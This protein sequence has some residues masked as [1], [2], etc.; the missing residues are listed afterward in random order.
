MVDDNAG[1]NGAPRRAIGSC[2]W[3]LVP[4]NSTLPPWATVPAM[5]SSARANSGTVCDRSMM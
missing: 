2:A 5:K 1:P 3:R 4:T